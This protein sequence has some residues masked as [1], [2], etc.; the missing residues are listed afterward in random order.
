MR[1]KKLELGEKEV[2]D[3]D[4]K[5]EYMKNINKPQNLQRF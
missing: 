1:C 3:L 2:G 5:I 4:V